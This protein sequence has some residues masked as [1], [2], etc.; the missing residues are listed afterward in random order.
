[1]FGREPTYDTSTDPIVRATAGEIRKRIAQYYQEPGHEHERRISLS[2]GSYVPEFNMPAVPA[3]IPEVRASEIPA[4]AAS[5]WPGGQLRWIAVAVGVTLVAGLLLAKPWA[6]H[7]ALTQF[8]QPILDSPNPVLICIGQRRFLGAS[9]ETPGD[10]TEDIERVR[11]S[12][13]DPAAPISLFRLYYMGRQNVAFPDVVTFGHVAGLLQSS[14][15]PYPVRGE[16]STNFS[17]LRDGQ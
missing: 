5:N 8:W 16:N 2:P 13:E 9:T 10:P 15:K 1:V 6:A 7:S 12:V 17:D 4:V 3:P 14:G 11:K